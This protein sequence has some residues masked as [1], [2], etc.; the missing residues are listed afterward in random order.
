[1]TDE[2]KKECQNCAVALAGWKRA[3]ADYDN[4]KKDLARE[5]VVMRQDAVLE[6]ARAFIAV[7]DNFDQAV[8]HV[9]EGLDDKTKGW[10]NGVLFIRTQLET[11]LRDLGLEPFGAAGDAFDPHL[12]DAIWN[13]DTPPA[14]GEAGG[15][16]LQ[17]IEVTHR[18]WKIGERVVR[19]AKVV[20]KK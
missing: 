3:L 18:G 12:H 6:A 16:A 2:E 7:L 17:I 11:S 14:K 13:A 5:R 8:K 9:P 15:G 20:V 10:V 19:S 4:L 1:M